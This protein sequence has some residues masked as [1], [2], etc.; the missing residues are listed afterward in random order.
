VSTENAMM[1]TI[2]L[3]QLVWNVPR[4]VSIVLIK[5][6]AMHA[7]LVTIFLL[8]KTQSVRNAYCLAKNAI[9]KVAFALPAQVG[10]F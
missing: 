3:I 7:H 4:T 9:I 2:S 1:A 10:W 8:S 6:I 5:I